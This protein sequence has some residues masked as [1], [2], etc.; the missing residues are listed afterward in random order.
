MWC[1]HIVSII[2]QQ[3]VHGV[4]KQ[5][6]N[7]VIE[8]VNRKNFNQTTSS[9]TNHDILYKHNILFVG[10]CVQH[11]TIKIWAELIN[12]FQSFDYFVASTC[13]NK[14]AHAYTHTHTSRYR[15]S[16]P[17]SMHSETHLHNKQQCA[18]IRHNMTVQAQWNS[19]ADQDHHNVDMIPNK[20]LAI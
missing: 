5:T 10:N 7:R 13:D 2:S 3:L 18:Y 17:P 19:S 9:L 15:A 14:Q 12:N 11:N 20:V 4:P 1:R 16:S 6:Q 8:L